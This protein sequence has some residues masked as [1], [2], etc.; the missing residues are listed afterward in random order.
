MVRYLGKMLPLPIVL[1]TGKNTIQ[2]EAVMKVEGYNVFL[3]CLS[4]LKTA[5]FASYGRYG[6]YCIKFTELLP[7]NVKKLKP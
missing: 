3:P 2:G 5:I 6:Q 7:I 1:L 4:L